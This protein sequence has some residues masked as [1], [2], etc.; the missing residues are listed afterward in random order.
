MFGKFAFLNYLKSE[1]NKYPIYEE[2]A[3]NF[4]LSKTAYLLLVNP[5][6]F[7]NILFSCLI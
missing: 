3:L 7:L 1:R 6:A 4:N 5:L 2:L